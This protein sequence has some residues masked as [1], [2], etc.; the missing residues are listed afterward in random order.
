MGQ[1]SAI[2]TPADSFFKFFR[3]MKVYIIWFLGVVAWNFGFPNVPPIADVIAAV[4]L[5]FTSYRLK[6]VMDQ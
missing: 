2:K 6:K 4:L 3:F 1:N 5:F